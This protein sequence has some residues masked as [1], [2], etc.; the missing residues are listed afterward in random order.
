MMVA[1][2]ICADTGEPIKKQTKKD[3]PWIVRL[4]DRPLGK[5]NFSIGTD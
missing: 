1:A 3:N 2:L 5:E 4:R